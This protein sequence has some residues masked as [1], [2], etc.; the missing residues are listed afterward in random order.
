[1][2]IKK[3]FKLILFIFLISCN[4]VAVNQQYV[5]KDKL[6]KD[7]TI[8]IYKLMTKK[9]YNK[10]FDLL[11]AEPGNKE[12]IIKLVNETDSLLE[13][14]GIPNDSALTLKYTSTNT[15]GTFIDVI[16]KLPGNL[17]IILYFND[18]I[19]PDQILDFHIDK[20]IDYNELY[21]A[22]PELRD[23]SNK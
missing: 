23:S 16:Y 10:I 8:S 22:F 6:Y 7:R 2:K 17:S 14:Y 4:N 3:L 12:L 18:Q 21:K 5:S 13:K 1:M 9:K 19:G 20:P 15:S 11:F